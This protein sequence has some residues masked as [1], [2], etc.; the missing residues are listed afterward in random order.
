MMPPTSI[1]GT[2]ITGATIDGTD[3][4][5]ITVDGQ[6]VFSAEF[7]EGF[8]DGNLN[9]YQGNVSDFTV[10]SGLVFEGSNALEYTG[11]G[12]TQ[13]HRT[14][15]MAPGDTA[16]LYCHGFGTTLFLFGYDGTDGYRTGLD[17]GQNKIFLRRI[18]NNST[19]VLTKDSSVSIPSNSWFE[20][21]VVYDPPN[22][23]VEVRD[24]SGNTLGSLSATDGTHSNTGFGFIG[25]SNS[26]WD[27][28]TIS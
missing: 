8:E 23:S 4:T 15:A 18:D 16:N 2:D 3:V 13:I 17:S 10:Q 5:E 20:A 11:G 27:S 12:F 7:F 1:D 21:E 22:L 24:L 25:E 9:E 19:T 28:I 26:F 6:T 14:D